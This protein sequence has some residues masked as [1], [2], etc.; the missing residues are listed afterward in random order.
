MEAGIYIEIRY[1]TFF[2][3]KCFRVERKKMFL[4]MCVMR[5]LVL[6]ASSIMKS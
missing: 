5:G 1:P 3:P 2:L 6:T 4:K